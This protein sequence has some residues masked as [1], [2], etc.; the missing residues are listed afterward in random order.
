MSRLRRLVVSNRYFFVTCNL[1]KDGDP[2][3]QMSEADF[4]GLASVIAATR[5]TLRFQ[6]TAWVFLP[7]H[8]H[9]VIFPPHPLTISSVMKI[10]KSRSTRRLLRD[11][12]TGGEL[13]QAR[14]YEH[15]LRTVKEYHDCLRYIHRNPVKRG[16]VT[17]QEEWKWSSIH[18]DGG[19]QEPIMPVDPV[20]LPSDLQARI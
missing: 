10:I 11:R 13:W 2:A 7:D 19:P 16:L 3:T 1:R 8:W 20:R 9:A 18:S 6:L 15:A 17:Q 4:A 14:F 5:L 12:G